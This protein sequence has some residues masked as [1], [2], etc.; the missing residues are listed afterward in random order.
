M[1]ISYSCKVQSVQRRCEPCFQGPRLRAALL[2]SLVCADVQLMGERTED[3]PEVVLILGTHSFDPKS[4]TL[5]CL[6]AGETGLGHLLSEGLPD[7][8]YL[9]FPTSSQHSLPIPF[10]HLIFLHSNHSSWWKIRFYM[11]V[12]LFL[13]PQ[14][15]CKCNEER[16]LVSLSAWFPVIS[17]RTVLDL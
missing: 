15:E 6:T 9:K 17:S 16:S 4:V 13:P 5:S 12:L 14:R 3:G 11:F 8:Y 2:S 10:S 7:H 1:F